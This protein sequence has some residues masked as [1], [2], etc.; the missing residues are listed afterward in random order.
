M[1]TKVTIIS[2]FLG[3]GK[4][5]YL[6]KILPHMNG[7][8]AVIENE[9]GKV[10]IDGEILKGQIPIKEIFAGCICCSVAGDLKDSITD[11]IDNYRPDHIVIEP[12]GVGSLSEIVK[13]IE[14]IRQKGNQ[15][16]EIHSL[17]TIVDASG[18]D[19]Y[20]EDFG[21]FYQ[22]QIRHAHV[23]LISHTED[24]DRLKLIE[25]SNKIKEINDFAAIIAD[26]WISVDGETL[27]ELVD[28][29]AVKSGQIYEGFET[30]PAD[31]VFAAVS[32][33]PKKSATKLQIE[34]MLEE[35]KSCKSGR[36]IRAKGILDFTDGGQ[37]RFNFTPFDTKL[38]Y[39]KDYLEPKAVVIGAKID[40]NEILKIFSI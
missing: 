3:A 1:T 40:K 22:D 19:E 33:A 24:I 12:S 31:R 5:T 18:F 23:I 13:V 8:I 37:V 32:I 7:S 4:T 35:L 26:D 2:G 28:S 34:G 25:I 38:E 20:I 17:I 9:F 16:I 30:V 11:L 6:K 27:Y 29:N 21:M 10:G 14:L 39:I 15:S 36:V